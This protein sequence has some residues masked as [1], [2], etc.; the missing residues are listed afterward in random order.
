MKEHIL[1][2]DGAAFGYRPDKMVLKNVSIELK[3]GTKNV[4]LGS[5]GAGKSTLF[6]MMNG[7]YQPKKGRLSLNGEPYSYKREGIHKIRRTIGLVFQ[8]PDIQLFASTILDDVIF[9]PMN[10]GVTL[11]EAEQRGREALK[12][13]G[14]EGREDDP[15]HILSHGQKKRAALAGVIAMDPDII[16][17]DEPTA[18][19]DFEGT[20]DL[21]HLIDLLVHQGKTLLISTHEVNW[22]LEWADQAYVLY[23]GEIALSGNPAE[24]LSHPD[25]AKMGYGKPV[26]CELSE[27]LGKYPPEKTPRNSLEMAH[28]LQK[29]KLGEQ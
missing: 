23:E 22:A 6:F 16:L 15:P 10:L 12:L 7:V 8:D 4:L 24:V 2:I 5:N 11:A 17:M 3:P 14:L 26:L 13:V 20:C 19:L 9:G 1:T 21:N 27:I 18:G 28:W 25:H 29:C